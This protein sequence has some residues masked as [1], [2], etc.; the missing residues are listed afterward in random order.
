MNILVVDD[1]SFDRAY[2]SAVFEHRGDVV[3]GASDGAAALE[4]VHDAKPDVIISDVLMPGM[5]GYRLCKAIREDT[6]TADIPFVFYTATYTDPADERLAGD[7]GADM[8]AVKPKD[9]D[10]IVAVVD[11]AVAHRAAAPKTGAAP[12]ETV[13]AEYEDA[14]VRKLEQTVTKLETANRDL[15]RYHLLFQQLQ[16]PT[17]FLTRD[18]R[19]LDANPAAETGYGYSHGDLLGMD[20]RRLRGPGG[21]S[22]TDGEALEGVDGPVIFESQG[23]NSGGDTFPVEVRAQAVSLG[24]EEVLVVITRDMTDERRRED[25]LRSMIESLEAMTYSTVDAFG[26]VVEQ[27]DPYTAGHQE[28]VAD[29]AATIASKLGLSSERCK[30]LRLAGLVHDVGKIGVP[31][32]ILNKPGR[33]SD[34]EFDIVRTHAQMSYDILSQ[35]KFPWPIAEMAYQHHERI[36]GS[37]YPR[38]LAGDRI[39][40]EA[41]ILACADVIEAMT[42]HRPYKAVLGLDRA[43]QEIIDNAGRIYDQQVADAVV[44]LFTEDGYVF[45]PISASGV[46]SQPAAPAAAT[47]APA[48]RTGEEVLIPRA[49]RRSAV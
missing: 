48:R 1:D 31:A 44:S 34:L 46:V 2:L 3:T 20:F 42:F 10:E 36:D 17:F 43:I 22:R 23:I 27:R 7:I 18:L 4:M 12:D 16:D 21:L 8:F 28:R 29:L 38:G 47:A 19:C 45:P 40:L 49:A 25:E 26:K 35:I 41:R 33:L 5:D 6:E 39:M 13:V 9:P 15:A 32:E 11:A 30:S 37:G 24:G 14:V